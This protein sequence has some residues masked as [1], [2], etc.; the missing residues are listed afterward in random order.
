MPNAALFSRIRFP[1]RFSAVTVNSLCAQ[2]IVRKITHI[3]AP[4]MAAARLRNKTHVDGSLGVIDGT[5]SSLVRLRKA[6]TL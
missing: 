1:S 6:Q 5:H 4:G 2:S 3:H